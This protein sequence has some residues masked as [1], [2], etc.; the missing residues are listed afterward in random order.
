[1]WVFGTLCH[2]S[3]KPLKSPLQSCFT[4]AL[5]AFILALL[6]TTSVVKCVSYTIFKILKM[7]FRIVLLQSSLS[8]FCPHF[9][10]LCPSLPRYLFSKMGDWSDNCIRRGRLVIIMV[11]LAARGWRLS[12][13]INSDSAVRGQHHWD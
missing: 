9:S 12:T 5:T 10:S 3:E 6:L 11:V 7:F 2:I 4:L 8:L 13:D 1:M